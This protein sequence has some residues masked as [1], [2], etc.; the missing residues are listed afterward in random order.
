MSHDPLRSALARLASEAPVELRRS[1]QVW[2]RYRRGRRRAVAGAAGAAG[3][4]LAAAALVAPSGGGAHGLV[5]ANPVRPAPAATRSGPA[6]APPSGTDAPATSPGGTPSPD[7]I[8]QPPGATP[9]GP[10]PVPPPAPP[11]AFEWGAGVEMYAA[12]SLVRPYDDVVATVFPYAGDNGIDTY[13]LDWGDGSAPVVYPDVRSCPRE[14]DRVVAGGVAAGGRHYYV[15]S[16]TYR[17]T[18]T[19]RFGGCGR[20]AQV[21]T[22]TSRVVVADD[23]AVTPALGGSSL[24]VR[25]APL[26]SARAPRK[27]ALTLDAAGD[28]NTVIGF[29]VVEW[30][31]G[32]ATVLRR[33][34]PDWCAVP[35]PPDPDF[36]AYVEHV[37]PAPGDYPVIAYATSVTCTNGAVGSRSQMSLRLTA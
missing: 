1:E 10:V 13:T 9:V 35:A 8:R 20:P 17:I 4:L 3:A 26:R 23:A 16:G 19:V 2:A 30:G 11:G 21:R 22:A 7:E 29:V 34:I 27:R 24:D 25:P 28:A 6:G 31:D 18:V 32:T 36:P 12:P 14:G 5:P 33:G 15:T 37:Y